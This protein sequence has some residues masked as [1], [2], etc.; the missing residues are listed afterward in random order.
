M[1]PAAELKAADAA[2]VASELKAPDTKA[3]A[4]DPKAVASDPKAADTVA[5]QENLLRSK[6]GPTHASFPK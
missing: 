5:S 6:S 4:S 2:A 3:V 1:E